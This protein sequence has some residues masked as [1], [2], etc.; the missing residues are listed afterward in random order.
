MSKDKRRSGQT[1][2][3]RTGSVVLRL[4]SVEP[5]L[6]STRHEGHSPFGHVP[7]SQRQVV[8][9]RRTPCRN[10]ERV[11]RVGAGNVGGTG[12]ITADVANIF[13]YG[14]PAVLLCQPA[15]VLRSST[16]PLGIC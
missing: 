15:R 6:K 16:S 12:G 4:S 3:G 7:A 1:K 11:R 10:V 5:A 9:P 2:S 13:E 8:P 14:R